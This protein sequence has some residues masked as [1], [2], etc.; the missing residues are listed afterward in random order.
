MREFG[1]R[2]ACNIGGMDSDLP[3]AAGLL[4]TLIFVGATFPMLSKALRTKDLRSYSPVNLLL[5]NLGNLIH[6]YYLSYLPPG[7]I[8]LLHAYNL[9]VAAVMLLAYLHYEARPAFR[10]WLRDAEEELILRARSRQSGRRGFTEGG[11]HREA[12]V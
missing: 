8:R 10:R 3:A 11:P 5:V 7:P 4:S 6:A 12:R 2:P 9:L 1:W